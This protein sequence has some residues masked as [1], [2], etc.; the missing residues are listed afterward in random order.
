RIDCQGHN[1]NPQTWSV[2]RADQWPFGFIPCQ[3][4]HITGAPVSVV[5]SVG[6]MQATGQPAGVQLVQHQLA[7]QHIQQLQAFWANQQFQEPQPSP[8]KDQ[9]RL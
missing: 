8:D 2:G 9:R 4:K 7:Y 1:Q 5:R 6:E 3:P